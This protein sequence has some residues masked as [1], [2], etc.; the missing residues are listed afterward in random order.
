MNALTSIGGHYGEKKQ[1]TDRGGGGQAECGEIHP[2]QCSGGTAHIHC[3][4]YPGYHQ[5]QDLCGCHLAWP[6]IYPDWYRR[7]RAG[8]QRYHPVPDE[9]SGADRHRDGGCDHVP[10][11]C[12]GRAGG[13]G[14][15]GSWHAAA[16]P[17]ACSPC[18]Q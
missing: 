14:C 12:E 1:K 18:G 5:G 17:Q 10:C 6:D 16:F 11:R 8:Q 7:N 9:S 4:G 13:C 3:P 15:Q 2:V